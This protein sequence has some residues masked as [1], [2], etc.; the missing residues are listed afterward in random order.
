MVVGT[1]SKADAELDLVWYNDVSYLASNHY[2]T[3]TKLCNFV[4]KLTVTQ[5]KIMR[6]TKLIILTRMGVRVPG[7]VYYAWQRLACKQALLGRESLL[8]GKKMAV[9]FQ[10]RG[11]LGFEKPFSGSKPSSVWPYVPS[12]D[13]STDPVKERM[14][15]FEQPTSGQ[16]STSV[17]VNRPW[18][19]THHGINQPR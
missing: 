1:R 6:G 9:L 3:I 4:A 19:V 8:E 15:G 7:F 11:N 2:S 16:R 17:S 13:P 5:A 12:I 18:F 10:G 14:P